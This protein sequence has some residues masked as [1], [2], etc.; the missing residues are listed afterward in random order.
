MNEDNI[1]VLL[2]PRNIN[3]LNVLKPLTTDENSAIAFNY[4]WLL[5]PLFIGLLFIIIFIFIKYRQK[6]LMMKEKKDD[7]LS[8]TV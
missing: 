4:W 1:T 8:S 6:K 3:K 7:T 2:Y 5:C